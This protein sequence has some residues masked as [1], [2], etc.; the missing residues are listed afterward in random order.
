MG[1]MS[2]T[3]EELYDLLRK[4][5]QLFYSLEALMHPALLRTVEPPPYPT[6]FISRHESVTP[7]IRGCSLALFT[8][9]GVVGALTDTLCS[10]RRA[11]IVSFQ[12]HGGMPFQAAATARPRAPDVPWGGA[13]RCRGAHALCGRA[14]SGRARLGIPLSDEHVLGVLGEE[15]QVLPAPRRFPEAAPCA[16]GGWEVHDVRSFVRITTAEGRPALSE[17]A[18]QELEQLLRHAPLYGPQL[19]LMDRTA[20]NE[21]ME[22]VRMYEMHEDD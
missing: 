7:S 20:S 13:E 9:A 6:A 15:Q 21:F 18:V 17:D 5:P 3:P 22:S 12:M 4:Q 11:R 2:V 16:P 1:C 14:P 19:R 8:P 10:F